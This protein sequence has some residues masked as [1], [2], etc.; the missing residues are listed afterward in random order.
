MNLSDVLKETEFTGLHMP[1]TNRPNFAPPFSPAKWAALSEKSRWDV[2]VC[3][4]G[5]DCKGPREMMK[6]FSN[7]VIRGALRDVMPAKVPSERVGGMI[8]T[9]VGLIIVPSETKGLDWGGGHYFDHIEEAA[10]ILEIPRVR[11]PLGTYMDIMQ[12]SGE[13]S[14]VQALF[15]LTP[16]P[17]VGRSRARCLGWC[18]CVGI[19][20]SLDMNSAPSPDPSPTEGAD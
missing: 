5:P 17:L 13:M 3:L 9:H 4:R 6:W 11:L 2:M 19:D 20:I 16:S 12:L 14:V 7:S 18:K 8:N 1:P 10:M 15:K